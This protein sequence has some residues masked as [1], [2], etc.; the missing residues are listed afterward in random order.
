MD[1]RFQNYMIEHGR[2]SKLSA[3]GIPLQNGVSERRNITMLDMVR[4]MMSF[5]Q[6]PDSFWD[7]QW[8]LLHTF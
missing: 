5:A 4:S 6:L 7:L 8:R 3:P 1:L 2:T